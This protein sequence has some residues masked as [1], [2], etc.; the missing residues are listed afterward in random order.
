M[1]A[2]QPA[3]KDRRGV[4]GGKLHKTPANGFPPF[5][6]QAVDD[7]VGWAQE[8]RL[9]G[10]RTRNANFM[11]AQHPTRTYHQAI[12]K[13][14]PRS[15]RQLWFPVRRCGNEIHPPF[16]AGSGRTMRN[17]AQEDEQLALQK[18]GFFQMRRYA[19]VP[20]DTNWLNVFSIIPIGL[21]FS[22]L[23]FNRCVAIINMLSRN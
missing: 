16:F 11:V 17:D 20:L 10:F 7:L 5:S 4:G 19:A 12:T 8:D 15:A 23:H 3:T 2:E 14:P 1:R 6:A 9:E 13:L 18:V 22:I 21:C